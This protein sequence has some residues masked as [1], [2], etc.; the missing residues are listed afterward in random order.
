[1]LSAQK[2]PNDKSRLGF[3]SNNKNKSKIIKKKK[4]QE[5]VKD[6]DKIVCFKCKIEGHHVRSFLLKKKP[7]SEKQQGKRPQILGYDQPRVEERSLP[8]KN[9]ANDPIVDKS[10]ENK[11]KKRTCYICHEKGHISSS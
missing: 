10:S 2:S 4:G 1:M 3:I 8:M 5:Q 6:L 9:Q 7:L 11:E